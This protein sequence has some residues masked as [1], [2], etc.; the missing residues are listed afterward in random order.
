MDWITVGAE[1]EFD[2]EAY[3]AEQRKTAKPRFL[4][5]LK[6]LADQWRQQYDAVDLDT[7]TLRK[8]RAQGRA[9]YLEDKE[10][11][12]YLQAFDKFLRDT[13]LIGRYTIPK[14]EWTHRLEEPEP[15]AKP[16]TPA[17]AERKRL[18]D[19]VMDRYRGWKKKEITPTTQDEMP[20]ELVNEEE[21]KGVV[22]FKGGPKELAEVEKEQEGAGM[23]KQLPG[24]E[25]QESGV[26]AA[27]SEDKT[28]KDKLEAWWKEM[29]A[30]DPEEAVEEVKAGGGHLLT[31]K[32]L[33]EAAKEL[34]AKKV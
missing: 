9:M 12:P 19:L 23:S 24:L 8:L 27:G 17:Q 14:R 3:K 16:L 7:D 4:K 21:G 29:L 20:E 11:D 15:E 30:M 18:F 32:E 34:S 26:V 6:D 33:E 22:E 13:H 1:E 10:I 2:Y 28:W 25:E 31:I 5:F